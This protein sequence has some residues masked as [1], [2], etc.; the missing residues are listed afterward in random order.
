MMRWIVQNNLGQTKDTERIRQ[1]CINNGYLYEPIKVIP[2]SLELPEIDNKEPT[3]F[4]G[5]TNFINN[6]YKSGRWIP[7]TF[8]NENF[9]IRAYNKNYKEYIASKLFQVFYWSHEKKIILSLVRRGKGPD[10]GQF[11]GMIHPS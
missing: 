11:A 9:T 8:F 4:Y 10:R 5:A 7:G 1:A 3:I 2:F 6:I